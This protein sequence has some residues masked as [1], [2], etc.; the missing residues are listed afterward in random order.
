MPIKDL[1]RRLTQVGVIRLGGEKTNPKRPGAKLETLR[2]TSPSKRL[3]D[4]VAALYG[5]DVQP[6]VSPSGPEWQVTTNARE[7]PVLVPPQRID[8]N[9][10]L[11]GNG[12]RDRMCNGETE[13][14][15]DQACMCARAL[16]ATGKRECKPTTRM[17]LML[18]DI[19]SLGTWKLESHGWNAAAELPMPAE[20]IATARQP[21]PAR[22]EIQPRQKRV[23]D[24]SKPEGKQ[25]ETRSYMVPVVHYDLLTPRQ[26]FGGQ[27]ASAVRD[28]LAAGQKA[29]AITAAAGDGEKLTPAEVLR[30]LRFIKDVPSLQELW[31]T[32]AR[33]GALTDDVKGALTSAAAAMKST[34]AEQT[35]PAQAAPKPAEPPAEPPAAAGDTVEAEIDEPDKNALWMQIMTEAGARKW[36]SADLE[37]RIFDRFDKSSDEIHG[38]Q[39]A[40]F[41]TEIQQ[42]EIS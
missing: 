6:W 29:P 31:K 36:N 11:W 3:V 21:I 30:L 15:R 17:S 25:I 26:A 2:F 41:L 35:V 1:Q 40:T 19:L 37:Q 22:L 18:A 42:G 28:A 39:M 14:I 33:D 5:G 23:F 24:P 7:I 13:R 8:P 34:P 20:A 16:A 10:E 12:F 4:A 9:Y 32:A 27:I 38:W